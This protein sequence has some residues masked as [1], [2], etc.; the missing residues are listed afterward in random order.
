M[1]DGDDPA[2]GRVGLEVPFSVGGDIDFSVG[3][4]LEWLRKQPLD[5]VTVIA[6]RAALRVIPAFSLASDPTG[7]RLTRRRMALR[8]FRAV[9]AVWTVSAFPAQHDLLRE[10]AKDAVTGLGNLQLPPSERAAA[11]ALAALLGVGR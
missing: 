5:V 6:V 3:G 11:Y 10:A 4:R 1:A 9:A 7:T 8:V 2:S